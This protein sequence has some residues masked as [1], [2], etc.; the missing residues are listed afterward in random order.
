MNNNILNNSVPKGTYNH[1]FMQS[2]FAGFAGLIISFVIICITSIILYYN[3]LAAEKVMWITILNKY[4]CAIFAA[5]IACAKRKSKGFIRGM[6]G[7]ATFIV[8]GSI[9]FYSFS[10]NQL[11][12]SNIFMDIVIC[13]VLGVFAG[14]ITV[15][16]NCRKR[17]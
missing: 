16:F 2:I 4:L 9:L 17:K 8:F 10:S 6:M 14:A 11:S 3:P 7:A 1:M 15:N 5:I 12:M 13:S